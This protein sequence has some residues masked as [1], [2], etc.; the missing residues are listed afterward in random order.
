MT[1][2]ECRSQDYRNYLCPLDEDC[3]AG[4]WNERRKQEQAEAEEQGPCQHRSI[5]YTCADCGEV[6]PVDGHLYPVITD[7]HGR[8]LD[9]KHRRAA[10]P[11]W[12]ELRLE[13]PDDV[14]A[15]AIARAANLR[16]PFPDEL[17]AEAGELIRRAVQRE[18]AGEPVTSS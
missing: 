16:T 13:V 5:V 9:G 15:L 12:P 18:Q 10:D 2:R 3:S 17:A 11:R 6:V 7:Q 14:T 8:V 1:L 4:C